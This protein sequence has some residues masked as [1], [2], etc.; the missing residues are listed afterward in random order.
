MGDSADSFH[1]LCTSCTDQTGKTYDLACTYIE[2]NILEKSCSGKMFN[3]KHL[4]SQ[5]NLRLREQIIDL[6]SNHCLD[7]ICVCDPVYIIGSDIL[8][9][10]EYG[11]SGS[12][13]IH[14]LETVR[15]KDN[16]N[17]ILFQLINQCVKLLRLVSGKCCC[18]LIQNDDLCICGKRFGDLNHLLL[19]NRKSSHLSGCIKI[20]IQLT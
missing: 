5:L 16:G 8:R 14:I 3:T 10:T 9:I 1:N 20:C 18:R 19:C 7:Q 6:T 12:Q 15:N 13:T 4:I 17:A 11:N 2:G